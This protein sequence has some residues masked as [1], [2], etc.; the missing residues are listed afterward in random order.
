[1][2]SSLLF[3]LQFQALRDPTLRDP[4]LRTAP[5]ENQQGE[6]GIS[7]ARIRGA[8][9]PLRVRSAAA[10]EL[11]SSSRFSRAGILPTA[12]RAAG[13][14]ARG[15]RGFLFHGIPIP[16]GEPQLLLLLRNEDVTWGRIRFPREGE[17]PEV[18]H[19]FP[20]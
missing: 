2:T 17:I 1:M 15:H 18:F 20:G 13:A 7:P 8:A 3:Q 11:P 19:P 14:M 10:P 12:G 6:H 9:G 16:W 5:M 4:S